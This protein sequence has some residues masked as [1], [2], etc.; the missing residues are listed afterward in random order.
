MIL[1][2]KRKN[3]NFEVLIDDEDFEIIN[4]RKSA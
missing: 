3:K 2:I 4:T 1:N